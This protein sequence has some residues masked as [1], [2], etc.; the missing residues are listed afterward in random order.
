M[1]DAPVLIARAYPPDSVA[2]DR[3]QQ[4]DDDDPDKG[5]VVK[6]IAKA[7]HE[8]PPG[9]WPVF[10]VAETD[11]FPP[12]VSWYAEAPRSVRRREVSQDI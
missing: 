6:E 8:K 5:V 10:G 9:T 7:S 11:R 3:Q 12:P 2:Q 4:D 1:G